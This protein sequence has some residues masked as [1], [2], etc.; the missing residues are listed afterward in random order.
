MKKVKRTVI[1]QKDEFKS[2]NT[3]SIEHYE[4]DDSALIP[5]FVKDND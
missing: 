3:F 1:E 4:R 5:S 2:K